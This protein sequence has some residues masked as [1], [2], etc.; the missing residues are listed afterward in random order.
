MQLAKHTPSQ[1]IQ[2]AYLCAL[3][4][5]RHQKS[6]SKRFTATA[7]F[8]K[9]A[10]QVVPVESVFDAITYGKHEIA[11]ICAKALKERK[12]QLQP[13]QHMIIGALRASI[14]AHTG[15]DGVVIDRFII[16]SVLTNQQAIQVALSWLQSTQLPG[17]LIP[18][19]T[20][21]I[22]AQV[23]VEST[24]KGVKPKGTRVTTSLRT[25]TERRMKLSS[26]RSQRR[27]SDV[28]RNSPAQPTKLV[29][30]P[31]SF[32]IFLGPHLN[33]QP[34]PFPEY[35]TRYLDECLNNL[36]HHNNTAMS[37]QYG[38][39]LKVVAKMNI[40]EL[41]SADG[42]KSAHF[43]SPLQILREGIAKLSTFTEVHSLGTANLP[44]EQMLALITSIFQKD[45]NLCALLLGAFMEQQI[46]IP[47]IHSARNT[48]ETLSSQT[49]P[50]AVGVW[51]L[52][53]QN[54]ASLLAKLK[55]NNRSQ[56]LV[57][58]REYIEG[59]SQQIPEDEDRMYAGKLQF[60]LHG[61]QQIVTASSQYISYSLEHQLCNNPKFDKKFTLKDLITQW[62]TIFQNDAL[63]LIGE[64]HRPLVARWLKWT[65]LVHDLREALAKYTCIGVTGFVNSGKSLLVKKL[66]KIEVLQ[67][68]SH[69]LLYAFLSL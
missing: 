24:Q 20:I 27:Y 57:D 65:I 42:G 12:L 35:V 64:S 26:Q 16:P 4:E 30:M 10:V 31:F 15:Y 61:M 59:F 58:I 9:G 49:A 38:A 5:Q 11:L 25:T 44:N 51:A 19:P 54:H 34:V 55:S 48:A 7:E 29:A 17:N 41:Y 1:I 33:Q 3:L 36:V 6:E 62:D 13:S 63:S 67:H 23:V 2:L 18:L 45:V 53:S 46:R 39:E 40:G 47:L 43:R 21:G 56:L 14:R 60:L 8:L 28:A 68:Y 50:V 32:P 22:T 37:M 66:F 52:F 69:S